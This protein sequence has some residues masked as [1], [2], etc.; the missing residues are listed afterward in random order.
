[1]EQPV[2]VMSTINVDVESLKETLRPV[3]C[4]DGM[5]CKQCGEVVHPDPYNAN[6]IVCAC[7]SIGQV[8]PILPGAAESLPDSWIPTIVMHLKKERS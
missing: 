7:P 8:D 1:M 5:F 4:E 3:A 6:Y 2:K